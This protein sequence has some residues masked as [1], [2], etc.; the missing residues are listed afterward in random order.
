MLGN[1]KVI[2]QRKY[3]SPL[4]V[5]A[6][7]WIQNCLESLKILKLL[8]KSFFINFDLSPRFYLKPIEKLFLNPSFSVRENDSHRQKL[9][10][11]FYVDLHQHIGTC[12]TSPSEM[13]LFRIQQSFMSFPSKRKEDFIDFSLSSFPK[14]R[15]II[16]ILLG[17]WK[18]KTHTRTHDHILTQF[19]KHKKLLRAQFSLVDEN[20]S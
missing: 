1:Q 6:S 5:I 18:L 14:Y 20:L 7:Y 3:W 17:R 10:E 4:R 8:W 15:N 16:W 11:A 2:W 19:G 12:R 13:I 9:F